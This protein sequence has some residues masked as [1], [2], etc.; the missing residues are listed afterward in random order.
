MAHKTLHIVDGESTGGTL[1]VSG[2]AKAEDILRWKDALYTGP[3]PAGLSLKRLSQVRSQFWT[4]GKRKDEFD[5]RNTQLLTWRQYEE[6][7]LWFGSTSLCQ[8]S[9]AQILAWF[10]LQNAAG[11]RLSLVT[12]YGGTLRPEQL[13][14]PYAARKPVSTTQIQLAK[15]LWYAFTAP[16]PV[17]LQRLL[18]ANLRALPEVRTTI[19]QLLE[20]YPDRWDG[21][22][23]LERKLLNEI[24]GMGSASAAFAVG[25][26]ITTERVGDTLLFDMLRG[27][28]T[29]SYP[30][31]N[32]AEPFSGRVESH[33]FNRAK[34]TLTTTGQQ[35]LAGKTDHIALNG[36]DRWVGGAHLLGNHIRWR[37]DDR[38][39]KVVSVRK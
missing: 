14:G 33:Q 13:F 8:L 23:R 27:F 6:I 10:S 28:V 29:A 20:D 26:V 38:K 36:I 7:V 19:D 34:L 22:S 30:L 31:L 3:V 18:S 1:K 4:K 2:L 15:R 21:L 5:Q 24:E 37:W 17:L 32:F 16:T 25:S 11:G 12:A 9:L 39:Q 35:V